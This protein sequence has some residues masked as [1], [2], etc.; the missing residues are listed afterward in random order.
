MAFQLQGN[1]GTVAE[2]DGTTFRALRV[3]NR[4]M[5]YGALGYYQIST[6]SG[7]MAAGMAANGQI[8]HARWTDA[9]RFCL[10][11]HLSLTGMR[12][13]TAFAA[14]VIDI[15]ATIVR[16][17]SAD[18]SGGTAATLTGNNQKLRT[19]MGSTLMGT[20]RTASTAALTAGT[21]TLDAQ[22]L[23]MIV[24]H[25]S[26]GVGA[27][28]PIIGSIYLPHR[29]LF[30]QHPSPGGHP[31]VFA[32][33]EGLVIRATV[34]ATGVWNFGVTFVWAEVSSF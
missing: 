7:S 3:T 21:Q 29:A 9:T 14:G 8:W 12:T 18:G 32:Q 13:T 24:T 23:G 30:D 33:N 20:I 25:S 27:A 5:E 15:K 34:P 16:V 4:P 19:S 6:L 11:L 2:I 28:T 26:G 22:D 10:P 17:W 1:S 31:L